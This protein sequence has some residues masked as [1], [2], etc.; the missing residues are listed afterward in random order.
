[1]RTVILLDVQTARDLSHAASAWR[2]SAIT[3]DGLRCRSPS[4]VTSD[5]KND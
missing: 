2:D 1:M 5:L 3:T 4:S